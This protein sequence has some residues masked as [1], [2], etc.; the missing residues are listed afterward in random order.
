MFVKVN[1][2]IAENFPYS[3]GELRKANPNVSFPKTLPDSALNAFGVFR[4][5]EGDAPEIS[6]RT[7]KRNRKDVPELVDGQWVLGWT[8]SDKSQNEIAAETEREAGNVRRKRNDK[9]AETDWT[10]AKDIPE[11][12]SSVWATYRQA[13]RDVPQQAGFPWD[14]QWPTQPE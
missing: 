5:T 3:I 14:V 7:Q 12:T 4:V 13:L 11:N 6:E 8:V 9:L 1:N 2:G 10:Q